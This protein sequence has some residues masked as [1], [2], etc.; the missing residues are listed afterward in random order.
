ME[1]GTV[2]R[3]QRTHT[4]EK[5]FLCTKC[6]KCFSYSSSLV[7]FRWSNSMRRHQRNHT[8]ERPYKCPDCG[9]TFKDFSSLISHHRVHKGERPDKCLE[10]G[11]CFSHSSSLSTHRRTHTGEKPSSCSDCGESFTQKQTLIL[12]QQ[13]H[14]GE[15]PNRCQECQKT[16]RTS[17][18]LTLTSGSMHRRAPTRACSAGSH[19]AWV[20]GVLSIR[21]PTWRRCPWARDLLWGVTGHRIRS[22]SPPWVGTSSPLVSSHKPGDV[23]VEIQRCLW[24]ANAAARYVWGDEGFCDP[25]SDL[26]V[27]CLHIEVWRRFT[28][29]C[30]AYMDNVAFTSPQHVGPSCPRAPASPW[31]LVGPGRGDV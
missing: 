6:G 2:L 28:S 24:G 16:F 17:S 20:P 14:T 4:K 18:H 5:H 3:H 19:S 25:L 9:K 29:R 23:G 12:H 21:G 1:S 11:E 10:C 27:E 13:I 26:N 30:L 15:M 22:L 31:G 8:G 7:I